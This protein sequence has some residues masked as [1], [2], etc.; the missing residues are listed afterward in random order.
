MLS[1][2]VLFIVAKKVYCDRFISRTVQ[3]ISSE[4][5]RPGIMLNSGYTRSE[6]YIEKNPVGLRHIQSQ[7]LLKK[8]TME[9]I[10]YKP[11]PAR[12]TLFLAF[13]INDYS[14]GILEIKISKIK[15]KTSKIK[16]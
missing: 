6:Y 12:L 7:G 1:V 14:L 2:C 13:I 4:N 9:S 11:Q 3:Q 8:S 10:F 5:I 15:A 16:N